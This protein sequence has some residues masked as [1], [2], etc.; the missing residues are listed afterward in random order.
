MEAGIMYG[1]LRS[2]SS[3]TTTEPEPTSEP[4][5]SQKEAKRH[6]AAGAARFENQ[7]G[8]LTLAQIQGYTGE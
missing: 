5:V 1:I 8:I 6:R 3:L 2:E 4:K 7:H